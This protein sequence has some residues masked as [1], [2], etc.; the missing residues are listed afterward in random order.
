MSDK[1]YSFKDVQL[2]I[3]GQVVEGYAPNTT[4]AIIQDKV[5]KSFF[6]SKLF[7]DLRKFIFDDYETLE[8][9]Y[10]EHDECRIVILSEVSLADAQG[11]LERHPEYDIAAESLVG[12]W[13]GETT[14]SDNNGT[15]WDGF[16][17]FQKVKQVTETVTVTSWKPISYVNQETISPQKQ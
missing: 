6:G 9:D 10:M 14:R 16:Y 13:M 17:E 5:S 8:E 1:K 3:C 4:I 11:F 7:D 12:A 2:T 15:Y